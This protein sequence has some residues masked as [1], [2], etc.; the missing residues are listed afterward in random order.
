MDKPSLPE[1]HKMKL[2]Q[3][4]FAEIYKGEPVRHGQ[5]NGFVGTTRYKANEP[6]Y[7]SWVNGSE[8]VYAFDD[9]IL[10]EIEYCPDMNEGQRYVVAVNA[11]FSDLQT[12]YTM[13]ACKLAEMGKNPSNREAFERSSALVLNKE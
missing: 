4:G 11:K 7:I 3:I 5:R 9:P 2:S 10:E 8:A 12:R 6:F 13:L 1:R